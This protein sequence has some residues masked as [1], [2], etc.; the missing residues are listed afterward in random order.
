MEFKLETASSIYSRFSRRD[1]VQ[2]LKDLGF[3]FRRFDGGNVAIKSKPSIVVNSI[4]DLM[5]LIKNF[6]DIVVSEDTIIIYDG[7]LE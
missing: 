7:F 4:E 2:K 1:H 6:G 5:K 3:T